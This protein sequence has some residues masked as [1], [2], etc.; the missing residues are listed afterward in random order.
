MVLL[1]VPLQVLAA[2]LVSLIDLLQVLVVPL[3]SLLT[4]VAGFGVIPGFVD[5]PVA[6]FGGTL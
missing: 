3:V 5:C 4:L 2:P 6:G 1:F